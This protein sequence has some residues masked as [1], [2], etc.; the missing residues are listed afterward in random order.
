VIPE[1]QKSNILKYVGLGV[2]FMVIEVVVLYYF[3]MF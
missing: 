2:I 1:K 3:K